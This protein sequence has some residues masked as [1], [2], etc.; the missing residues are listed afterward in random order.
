M[1]QPLRQLRRGPAPALRSAVECELGRALQRGQFRLVYQPI[2]RLGGGG[3]P[4]FEAL[5]RWEHPRLGAVSPES[6]I[7][8]AEEN[9]Q[10]LYIGDWVF[11]TAAAECLRLRRLTGQALR[12]SVNVSPLQLASRA[13]LQLWIQHLQDIGLPAQAL[14]LEITERVMSQ[15]P[16]RVAEH[17]Q[18]LAEAGFR[19]ALDD[20]GSGYSNLAMLGQFQLDGLKLDRSLTRCLARSQRHRTIT[21]SIVEL[22]HQL[23]MQVVAEGVE[24]A[25]DASITRALGC[26]FG[27]GYWFA[28]PLSAQQV[29]QRLAAAA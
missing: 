14:T 17:L 2:L 5:L 6:F 3:P 4:L 13:S 29:E 1:R 7:A 28:R 27:Q 10:I 18:L 20:F 24:E 12:L 11:R 22:A 16:R 9:G 25:D 26:D 19:I 21:S 15:Q 8:M 23:Q